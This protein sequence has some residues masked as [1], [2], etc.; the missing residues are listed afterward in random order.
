MNARKKSTRKDHAQ[1]QLH[2]AALVGVFGKV[3]VEKK[4]RW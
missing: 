1:L 2:P 4:D 3:D